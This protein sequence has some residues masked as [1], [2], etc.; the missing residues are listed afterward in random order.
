[1][2]VEIEEIIDGIEN[3]NLE[4]RVNLIFRWH[5]A[6]LVELFLHDVT[7]GSRKLAFVPGDMTGNFVFQEGDA[8]VVFT[9][10]GLFV[11]DESDFY[12]KELEDLVVERFA[13][14]K[15]MTSSMGNKGGQ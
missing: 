7:L 12:Y 15:K 8:K 3:I 11:E 1:M 10:E 9:E 14:T 4:E 5:N 6:L 13:N 2:K